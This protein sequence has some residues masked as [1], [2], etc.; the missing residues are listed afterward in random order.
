VW[1]IFRRRQDPA[2]SDVLARLE[3]LERSN[4]RLDR[5]V[6]AAYGTLGRIFERAG[7]ATPELDDTLPLPVPLYVVPEKPR[8]SA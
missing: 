6:D 7:V 4:G 1:R 3:A 2:L 8:R 5:R